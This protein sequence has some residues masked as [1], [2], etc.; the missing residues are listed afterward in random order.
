M[1][2]KAMI[3]ISVAYQ[4]NWVLLLRMKLAAAVWLRHG[5]GWGESC[6]LYRF[7]GVCLFGT[8]KYVKK[9]SYSSSI[10]CMTK[11]L[12]LYYVHWL[13]Y[14]CVLPIRLHVCS[15]KISGKG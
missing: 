1:V 3:T 14:I 6:Y 11:C 4:P 8:F 15:W 5:H 12:I 10:R 2:G 7:V 9:N 13:L